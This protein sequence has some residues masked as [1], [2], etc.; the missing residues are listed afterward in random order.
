MTYRR[1][2]LMIIFNYYTSILSF[3]IVQ[4]Q[5]RDCRPRIKIYYRVTTTVNLYQVFMEILKQ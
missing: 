5:N 1:M 3:N 4:N 2:L